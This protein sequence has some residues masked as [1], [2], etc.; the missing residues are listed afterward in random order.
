V[1]RPP[2]LEDPIMSAGLILPLLLSLPQAAD[3]APGAPPLD[4]AI[5][6]EVF[7]V[8]VKGII[9]SEIRVHFSARPGKPFAAR[10]LS[11][12]G[13]QI[14]VRGVLR[15]AVGGA[16]LLELKLTEVRKDGKK[17]DPAFTAKLTPGAKEVLAASWALMY[18]VKLTLAK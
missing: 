14:E 5:V 18:E 12:G 3:L 4:T 2:A 13:E 1:L 16:F 6:D 11:S 9:G 10:L 17:M 15:A 7:D 8:E